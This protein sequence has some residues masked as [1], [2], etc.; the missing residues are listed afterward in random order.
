MVERGQSDRVSTAGVAG[1][2][3]P[4]GDASGDRIDS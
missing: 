3:H 2:D 1:L 4:A